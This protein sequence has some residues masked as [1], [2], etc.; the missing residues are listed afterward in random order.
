MCVLGQ[1]GM[2]GP[3]RV[4]ETLTHGVEAPQARG[5]EEQ[6]SSPPSSTPGKSAPGAAGSEE[7]LGQT[8]TTQVG[9]L[10]HPVSPFLRQAGLSNNTPGTQA[11]QV[12]VKA[13]LFSQKVRA[14]ALQTRTPRLC[15]G[16]VAVKWLRTQ[17]QD[18]SNLVCA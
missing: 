9:N 14:A 18:Y 8:T 11:P 7:G 5:Q 4:T 15:A 1:R 6:A 3:E 13:G 17:S 12:G 16:Q 10:K 2:W